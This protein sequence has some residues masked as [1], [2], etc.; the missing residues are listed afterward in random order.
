MRIPVSLG[1]PSYMGG[2][3]GQATLIAD[4]ATGL[5]LDSLHIGVDD[6]VLG[7]LEIK[8]LKIDYASM[9]N[10]W[11]GSAHLNIPAGSPY[12]AI[13]VAVRFDDGDFNMGS[14][15]VTV[16]YPGRADLHRHVSERVRRRL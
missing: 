4:N 16:P 5:H 13:D 14:F 6:L 2:V 11:T 10:V 12:F 3:T 15:N 1:L 8:D 9:G 7:A